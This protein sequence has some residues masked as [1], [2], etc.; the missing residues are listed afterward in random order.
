MANGGSHGG[1]SKPQES[2]PAEKPS[3]KQGEAGK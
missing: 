3:T 2:K 1:S